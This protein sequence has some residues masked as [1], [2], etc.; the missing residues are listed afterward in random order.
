MKII[1]IC[2]IASFLLLTANQSIAKTYG[3][4]T[5]E[6]IINVYDGDT[7]RVDIKGY[8]CHP[9]ICKNISM[10]I[11]SIDTPEIKG[12]CK[13]E[14]TLAIEARNYLKELLITKKTSMTKL[15]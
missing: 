3:D 10:R 1:K 7:I 6:N 4:L 2:L 14:K 12:K 5:V 15:S 11:D 9:I 8:D 13:H